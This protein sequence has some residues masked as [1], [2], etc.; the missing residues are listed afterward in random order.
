MPDPGLVGWD[1][2]AG[3]EVA[4]PHDPGEWRPQLVAHPRQE[5]GLHALDLVLPAEVAQHEHGA[6]VPWRLAP[7]GS[8]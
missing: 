1:R 3:H 6:A 2:L 5:L 7:E 8:G 4:E